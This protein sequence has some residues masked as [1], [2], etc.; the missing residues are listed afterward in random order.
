MTAQPGTGT[1]AQA[2]R[3]GATIVLEHF[4]K[5][6]GETVAVR[7]LTFQV[8]AGEIFG[9]IGPDGAGKTTTLRVI[10]TA[11]E[12]T[13]GRVVVAGHDVLREPE[14]VKQLIGYMPQRF[15]L[16]P[17]LTV[18]EN[19][20]F[21]ADM[22][23]APAAARQARAAR[24]LSFAR[25]TEFQQRR[26]QNLS[27]G[28]QKKLALAATLMHQPRLLLL[29]EPTT[30]VDPVSRREFWDLL[31]QIHLEGVTIVASTPYLDEAERCTRVALMYR[32][33]LIACDSPNALREH[34][35]AVVLEGQSPR[36][37]QARKAIETRPGVLSASAH[38][39]VIRLLV[40]SAGRA[41][42]LQ[43]AWAGQGVEVRGLREIRPRLEDVFV[44]AVSQ[45]AREAKPR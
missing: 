6:F 40:D 42:E 24:L 17:D 34:L 23:G 36:A 22:Y 37:L 43:A 4:G 10:A 8:N 39:D 29:D 1:S 11:M 45:Q 32:G 25:L 30:G 27:G 35:G 2:S 15:A 5:K 9:L 18:I 38:G 3:D 21:F 7:D 13:A 26:A 41:A 16:Y 14:A 12:P 44:L 20:N 19:L 33:E 28:M 31:T